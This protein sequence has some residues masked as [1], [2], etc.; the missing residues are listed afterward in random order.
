MSDGLVQFLHRKSPRTEEEKR[1]ALLSNPQLGYLRYTDFKAAPGDLVVKPERR[2][3]EAR[4]NMHLRKFEHAKALDAV[5]VMF[6]QRRNPEKTYSVL[7]ELKR[8]GAL[9][10]ALAGRDERSLAPIV[11]FVGKHIGDP[12]FAHLLIP[13]AQEI[14]GKPIGKFE[15]ISN[16]LKLRLSRFVRRLAG[17][18]AQLGPHVRG[19]AEARGPRV[20]ESVTAAAAA[21]R[22]GTHPVRVAVLAEA[23]AEKRGGGA[24]EGEEGAK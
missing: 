12:R 23:Q 17:P 24:Q 10:P 18:A 19:S 16:C 7:A 4:H 9:R 15:A 2:G 11:N 1:E 20:E 5:A 14:L 22:A 8:R 6:V 3:Q 21:G 13:V